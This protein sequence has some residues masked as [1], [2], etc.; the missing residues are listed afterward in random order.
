MS[1]EPSA[2]SWGQCPKVPATVGNIF[3][4]QPEVTVELTDIRQADK[5]NQELFLGGVLL[6]V[7]GALV[8]ECVG[9][10]FEVM[11]A[12]FARRTL[13]DEQEP[14]PEPEPPEPDAAPDDE[15]DRDQLPLF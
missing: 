10:G 12:R 9:T 5:Y 1:S 2:L 8:I 7:L 4:D 13:R 3:W 15:V 11:E 6:G 14:R